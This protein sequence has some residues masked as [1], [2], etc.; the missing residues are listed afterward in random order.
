MK[1]IEDFEALLKAYEQDHAGAGEQIGAKVGDRVRG[2]VVSIGETQV[3]VDLGGKSEGIM[4]VAA[5]SDADGNLTVGVGDPVEATITAIEEETGSLLL[6]SQ[7]GRHIHGLDE[8]E[9]AFRQHLPVEGR[10]TGAIKGGVEVQ[11]AGQRAFCPASQIDIRFVEDLSEFVG[12]HLRFR[13]TKFESG[14]RPNLVVSRRILLEE[15]QQ[16]LAAETRARIEE[17]AILNGTISSVKDYGAFVDLGGIEGMVHISELAYGH[18]KHPSEVVGEGQPVEVQV[19]RIEQ[20]DNPK[21]PEKISLSIR[22]LA[23]DPWRDAAER[24]PVGARVRGTV[25]RLQSFGA[26]VEIEP[27]LEGMVH[28]SELGAERRISH[29]QEVIANGQEVEAT[30][31]GVDPEKRRISLSLDESKKASESPEAKPYAGYEKPKEG[32]GTLGDLLRESMQK[33]RR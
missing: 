30:V 32:F 20:T 17:G 15:E 2:K 33:Q 7:Q 28:V 27:G 25:T 11:I 10:V 9:Q 31:L 18:V 13:I 16:A 4:E 21:R 14:R 29:P 19:L 8:L 5:L 6:G 26:F 3:F 12:Q 24:Y 22:A 1:D 23:R